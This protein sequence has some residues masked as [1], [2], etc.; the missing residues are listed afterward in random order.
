LHPPRR[1]EETSEEAVG[2][3]RLAGSD[4][5]VPPAAL[6]G[7]AVVSR[8][9]RVAGQCVADDDGVRRVGVEL[10]VG[11]VGDLDRGERGARVEHERV[12]LGV[13]DDPFG[14]GNPDGA[15]GC[16]SARWQ[17]VRS[18]ARVPG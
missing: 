3:D 17:R 6:C 15:A 16:R 18:P 2:V 10:S 9:V 12:V 13:E 14:L 1:F 7:I 8:G 11:L 4:E 5:V